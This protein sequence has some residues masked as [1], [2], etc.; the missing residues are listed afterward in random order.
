MYDFNLVIGA[1]I[2]GVKVAW[3]PALV[4]FG[5]S[6]LVILLVGIWI[7][8]DA[9]TWRRKTRG[10]RRRFQEKNIVPLSLYVG[11]KNGRVER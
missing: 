2:W 6:G 3:K 7:V 5:F 4:V 9:W 8:W 1:I 10:I 11:P